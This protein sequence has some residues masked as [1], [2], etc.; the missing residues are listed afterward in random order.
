MPGAVMG[1]DTLTKSALLSALV[2]TLPYVEQMTD[3]DMESHETAIYFTWR[4]YRFRVTTSAGVEEV[5]GGFLVGS[6][7][8][9]LL[10]ALLRFG[11]LNG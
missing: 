2:R 11:R 3:I 7:P 10:Q 4:G 6:N 8:A 5:D 9:I 1:D